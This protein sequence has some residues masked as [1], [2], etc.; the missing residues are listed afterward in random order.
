[1]AVCPD[2]S[3]YAPKFSDAFSMRYGL[4]VHWD[5]SGGIVH[6]DG[7]PVGKDIEIYSK[8][9][10]VP[11]VVDEIEALGFE[12]LILTSFHG[13]GTM[14]HPCAASDKWRGEGYSSKRDVIGEMIHALK[15]KGIGFIM[16]TH[17]LD[18]H[19]Y[20]EDQRNKLGWNDPTDG[21]KTWNDF[22][23]DVFG[24]IA[25]KYG[26]DMMGIGFD[27]EFGLSGNAE[28]KDKLDMK[29]LRQTILDAAP[30][31]Q[32]YGLPGPNAC[33]HFGMKEV[34][35]PNWLDPWKSKAEDDY[36]IEN[37][38]AYRR[39]V[40][41]VQANH[42]ATT[43]PAE[44][45]IA[46]LTSTQL[47]RYS[48]LQAGAA[49]HG[50]GVAWSCSPYTDGSWENNIREA[51]QGV[52]DLS[53]DVRAALTNV[54]AS[55]SYPTLE[56]SKISDLPYGVVATKSTD[57]SIEYI[58][59]LNKPDGRTLTLPAPADG[60]VFSSAWMLKN[61]NKVILTQRDDEVEL[62][63][64]DLDGDEWDDV[65]TVIGIEVDFSS[66]ETNL[67]LHK[68]VVYS[69][70]TCSEPVWPPGTSSFNAIYVN[71]GHTHVVEKAQ[72]WSSGNYGWSSTHT[73]ETCEQWIGVDLGQEFPVYKVVVYPRDDEG[74]EG[75]GFPIC[76]TVELSLDG[77]NWQ[78]A[79]TRTMTEQ[80]KNPERV[81]FD[82]V[83]ARY[84]RI[85][86][87]ELRQQSDD[88]LYSMQVVELQVYASRNE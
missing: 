24:E 29:R 26:K 83:T 6:A 47:Y 80:T 50:P 17:P 45:G 49:V 9:I 67:A 1:M 74:H 71:D 18:G 64:G 39:V 61:G 4:F 86:G 40:A 20:P 14:L 8:T 78:C 41:I 28:W 16:F 59:V 65:N 36:D 33:C 27:S 88:S 3:L 60:K 10:N 79:S 21:Y 5:A 76:F 13:L 51:F 53:K 34:W 57:D 25:A 46:H 69:S 72:P 56:G 66:S 54:N 87:T 38:P 32:L 23:N 2:P 73:V 55:T 62:M 52:I 58:H 82:A 31:M 42:W 77:E 37:W 22:I 19:D 44:G 35:R 68:H 43:V 12:Y 85:V 11:A 81:E 48:V 63:L 30:S 70:S 84:V 75:E 7:T 15:Q